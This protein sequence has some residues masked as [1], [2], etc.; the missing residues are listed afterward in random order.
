MTNKASKL[1][2]LTILVSALL[3][4][5]ATMAAAQ[6]KTTLHYKAVM[7]EITSNWFPVGD[8][9]DGHFVG[10][11]VYRGVHGAET[12]ERWV[13]SAV[14]NTDAIKGTGTGSGYFTDTYSDGSTMSGTY[15]FHMSTGANG[16]WVESL[17]GDYVSG[18]GRF[19]GI[20]GT[21]AGTAR[22]INSTKDFASFNEHEGTGTYTLPSK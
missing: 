7:T 16:L 8:P 3:L 18:T 12:G 2:L 11:G 17:N 9:A 13:E 1:V 15:V 5:A 21:W 10:I 14:G 19:E 20:K 4:S 6:T 22:Q